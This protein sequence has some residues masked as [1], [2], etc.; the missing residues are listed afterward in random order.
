MTERQN[1]ER[2]D[3]ASESP[4]T[5]VAGVE[6]ATVGFG[7]GSEVGVAGE[8]PVEKSCRDQDRAIE[9]REVGSC[10]DQAEK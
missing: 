9:N 3:G 7:A 1:E 8:N 6:G 10:H 4:A 5:A 2:L